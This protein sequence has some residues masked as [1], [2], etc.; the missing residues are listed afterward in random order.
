MFKPRHRLLALL[1]LL[2][3]VLCC[4]NP[5]LAGPQEKE[6]L[7][8][9]AN[10]NG[11]HVMVLMLRGA[12][13][14]VRN[15]RRQTP[16]HLA[17]K[18]DADSAVKSLLQYPGLDVNGINQDG[19]TPLM[20]AAIKGRL[21]WVQAL[22]RRGAEINDAGWNPLHYAASGPNPAV[23]SWL[24]GQGAQVDAPS[25]NGTT[26]LMMAAGYGQIDSVTLLLKAG[27]VATLRN[28]KGLDAADFA[29][30]AGR[31]DL[32]ERLRKGGSSSDK[33]R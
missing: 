10:D 13:P 6:L 27:A 31:D 3:A 15:E 28:E 32:A 4:G 8:A 19:E 2:W 33:R 9:A 11:R 21:D 7:D 12:D 23:V 22:V 29:L 14:N 24:L 30:R 20:L 16:L 25:P 5:A 18:N 26:A 17:L 1:L